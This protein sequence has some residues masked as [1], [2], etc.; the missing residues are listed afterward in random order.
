MTREVCPECGG[1]SERPVLTGGGA[2]VS[3]PHS[4]HAVFVACASTPAGVD[5]QA[6]PVAEAVAQREN[7]FHPV[8]VTA[9]DA[10]PEAGRPAAVARLRAP[11]ENAQPLRCDRTTAVRS[12]RSQ[13]PSHPTQSMR[14]GP[15][16]LSPAWSAYKC[17]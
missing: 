9:L 6:V 14:S 8:E 16:T 15:G 17:A 11:N 3:L 10:L 7:C 2:H 12:H 4:R 5:A 13:S 1:P